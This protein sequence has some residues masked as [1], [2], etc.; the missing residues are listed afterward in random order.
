MRASLDVARMIAEGVP[1][2]LFTRARLA[3]DEE[4]VVG[5]LRMPSKVWRPDEDVLWTPNKSADLDRI[6]EIADFDEADGYAWVQAQLD[7]R[8]QYADL[9]RRKV[10]AGGL[11]L[12]AGIRR[13]L[14]LE[15]EDDHVGLVGSGT[16]YGRSEDARRAVELGRRLAGSRV[17]RDTGLPLL[18]GRVS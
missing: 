4:S 2:R 13:L 1:E 14:G 11:Q 15:D 17:D 16:V 12:T 10:V 7:R 6:G 9:V 5:W 8:R 3:S 18:P